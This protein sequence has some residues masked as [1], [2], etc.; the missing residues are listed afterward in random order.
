MESR[1]EGESQFY[2][3]IPSLYKTDVDFQAARGST[4][5]IDISEKRQKSLKE[6]LDEFRSITKEEA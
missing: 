3:T 5:D 6:I 4:I 1:T 2:E